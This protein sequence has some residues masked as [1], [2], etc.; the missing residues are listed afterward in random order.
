M[1]IIED[2]YDCKCGKSFFWRL[3]LPEPGEVIAY[4]FDS[5]MK[6]VKRHD[7]LGD[8]YSIE[9]ECPKCKKRCYTV[10][11]KHKESDV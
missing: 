6:H 4:K 3:C 5:A 2:T 11:S 8:H 9:L 1:I 10:K 7:D